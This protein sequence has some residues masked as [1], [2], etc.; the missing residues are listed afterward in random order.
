MRK[1]ARDGF[2]FATT[3]QGSVTVMFAGMAIPL[4]MVCGLAMD[5]SFYVQT[6]SVLDTAANTAALHAVRVAY[7]AF[8]TGSSASDATAAGNQAGQQWF[9]SQAGNVPNLKSALNVTVSPVTYNANT[10]TFTDTVSYSG[11]VAT[12]VGSILKITQQWPIGGT[13]SATI[14]ASS[15][16]EVMMLV[17]NSSSMLIGATP[18][19]IIKMENLTIC[20]PT[21]TAVAAAQG[22]AGTYSW[23]Y[24]SGIGY[25]TNS[26]G[27]LQT[28]P[29]STTQGAC[30]TNFTGGA[31]QCPSPKSYA[32]INAYGFCPTGTGLPDP[33]KR[34]DPSTKLIAN[35]PQ[36]PCG[37][38]CHTGDAVNDYYTLA[39]RA[40]SPPT[41]RFD[42]I[43]S[44]MS[45]VITAIKNKPNAAN[46]YTV[47]VYAFNSTLTPV[48]PSA[49]TGV[50]A[51]NNFN[52]AATDVANL[53]SPVVADSPNTDFIDAIQ[54]VAANVTQAGDGSS[55]NSGGTATSRRKNI[56]IITDGLEDYSP[57][58]RTIGPMT[59]LNPEP[60]CS[61]M[62]NKGFNVY[63]LYTPY[64]PLPNEFY[65]N[66][67]PRGSVEPTVPPAT[68]NPIIAALQAC[69]STPTQFY[70]AADSTS[71]NAA[72]TQ[73]LTSATASPG[74][75]TY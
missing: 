36:A 43:Q 61:Q 71:I 1:G 21:V 13:S 72:L 3:R 17:D 18:A 22:L 23:I 20:P 59:T 65:L 53:T 34:I 11:Y 44:A 10:S 60:Y 57:T 28:V 15:Y 58:N 73:M 16:V 14:S 70:Q 19:D 55:P 33:N 32:S 69:A 64:Y 68:S 54:T 56:F 75:I 27:T 8:E 5:Y 42:V 37:F 74:R 52:Q 47:G 49:Y 41:L 25:G 67:G 12:H 46:L 9:N 4:V 62:K 45:N 6:Q 29:T 39:R 7:Q 26:N 35:I 24:P 63:V 2:L 30:D 50:E 51:D 48:H 31:A 66:N 38:A 40:S